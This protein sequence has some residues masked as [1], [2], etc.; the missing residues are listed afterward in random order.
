MKTSPVLVVDFDGCYV[1]NDYFAERLFKKSIENPL[2]VL[3]YLLDKKQNWLDLKKE[4][5]ENLEIS[6][7]LTQLVNEAVREF[8]HN[9][10][11]N[12]SQVVL[13]SASPDAFVKRIAAGQNMFDEIHGSTNTNL[14]AGEKLSFI[15]D[16]YGNNFHYIGNS[17]DDDVILAAA[18]K[19]FKVKKGQLHEY[20]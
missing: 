16:R 5:L 6:Y 3:G 10:R 18:M 8:I 15:R 4:L 13:V 11:K 2:I 20:R 7:P 17:A 1:K 14:K 19:G 12:Y 9:N